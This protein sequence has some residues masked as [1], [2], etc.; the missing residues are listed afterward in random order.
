MVGRE[1]VV[2]V[3]RPVGNGWSYSSTRRW[4][5]RVSGSVARASYE[6]IILAIW[7]VG[8]EVLELLVFGCAR[9]CVFA[10]ISRACT[11]DAMPN[12]WL[13]S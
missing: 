10:Q 1:C 6:Y 7:R 9:G 4:M 5:A 3:R 13:P 2:I 8:C 11:F 12:K